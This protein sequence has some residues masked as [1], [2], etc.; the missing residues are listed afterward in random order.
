MATGG[1]YGSTSTGNTTYFQWFIFQDSATQPATP[2]G[3]SWS[4]I[5]NVGTPPSGWSNTPTVT[6]VN[7]VWVSIGLVNSKST[8]TISWS[9]AG[10]LA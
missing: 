3:G 5:T 1:L 10:R 9:T 7:I 8:A 2:T 4:F 6:P